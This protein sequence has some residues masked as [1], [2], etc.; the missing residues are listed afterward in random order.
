M[1]S[2]GRSNRLSIDASLAR[3]AEDVMSNDR[4]R[5]TA[6]HRWMR[7]AIFALG[8]AS[9]AAM[10]HAQAAAPPAEPQKAGPP[11]PPGGAA[12]PL[13]GV[14]V[15]GRRPDTGRP[16]PDDKKAQFDAEV[17]REAAFQEYRRSTP[18][19]QPNDKGI[20]DP[21]DLSKDFPG[22]QSYIP[23]Q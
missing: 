10:A 15:T 2:Q 20:A 4:S 12:D 14:T 8:L 3:N 22:L 9:A 21:N 19:L 6:R 1:G 7:S 18:S 13:A 17:A 16:I 5:L 23:P 11:A